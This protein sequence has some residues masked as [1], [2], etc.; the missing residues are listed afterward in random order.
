MRNYTKLF[1]LLALVT[2]VAGFSGM[3]FD[4]IEV[5]RIL[6]LVFTDLFVVSLFAHAI[7]NDEKK[8]RYQKVEK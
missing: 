2:A 4:G 5:V 1:L 8:L 6:C 3:K 7:F